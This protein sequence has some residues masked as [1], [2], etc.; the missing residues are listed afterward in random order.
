M[1]RNDAMLRP[2]LPLVMQVPALSRI[3]PAQRLR[4]G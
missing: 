4:Q 2:V 3:A 1:I